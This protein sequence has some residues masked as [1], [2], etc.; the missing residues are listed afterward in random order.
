MKKTTHAKQTLLEE[1]LPNVRDIL[2]DRGSKYGVFATQAFIS[3]E[4]EHVMISSGCWYRMQ[5]DQREALKM[6]TH[7][8][9]RI[10]NGNPDYADSWQDIAG[11]AELVASRLYLEMTENEQPPN[12]EGR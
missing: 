8:I 7:K 11:Y 1:Y 12:R 4:L 10:L 9:S 3:Q 6:I 2:K 5:P